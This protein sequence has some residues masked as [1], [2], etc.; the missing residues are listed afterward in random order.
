[1]TPTHEPAPHPGNHGLPS[2]ADAFQPV[3][4][5]RARV[6]ESAV[7]SFIH[8]SLR[9]IRIHIEEHHLEVQGPPFSICH[10]APS[11]RVDVEAGWPVRQ[12]PAAGRICPGALPV[13]LVRRSR[14]HT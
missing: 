1:M 9:D 14:E 12:A 7:P 5:V 10:S 13:G 2:S 11:H 8:D 3:L 6:E 4:S